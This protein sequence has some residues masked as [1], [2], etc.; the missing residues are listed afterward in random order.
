MRTP[1]VRPRRR[2]S[3]KAPTRIIPAQAT[4]RQHPVVSRKN[5]LCAGRLYNSAAQCERNAVRRSPPCPSSELHSDRVNEWTTSRIPRVPRSLVLSSHLLYLRMVIK[6]CLASLL[7]VTTIIQGYKVTS[8]HSLLTLRRRPSTGVIPNCQNI[9]VRRQYLCPRHRGSYDLKIHC[10][11][12]L[13]WSLR[14]F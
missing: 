7:G 1:C 2:I 9:R 5:S 10:L 4:T 3:T 14:E 12:L 6:L 13:M 8:Q 11:L